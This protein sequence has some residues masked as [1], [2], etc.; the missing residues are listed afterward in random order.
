MLKGETF[1]QAALRKI[2]EETGNTAR[3]N[4]VAREILTVWNTYFSDSSWD[5]GRPEQ[6]HGCQTVNVTVFCEL[7]DNGSEFCVDEGVSSGTW[8]VQAHKWVAVDELLAPGK[9]DKYVRLN[10][11][12]AAGRG[13]LV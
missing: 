13:L 11:E 12:L 3:S 2:N 1:Y 6:E 5:E 4:I 10:V 9:Y 7:P 8:A